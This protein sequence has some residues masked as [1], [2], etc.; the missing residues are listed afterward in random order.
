MRVILTICIIGSALFAGYWAISAQMIA[1]IGPDTLAQSR[2][3]D[4]QTSNVTGFPFA[5]RTDLENLRWRSADRTIVWD[6]PHVAFESASYQPNQISARFSPTHSLEYASLPIDLRQ[7]SMVANLSVDQNLSIV[8]ADLAI[9]AASAT[10]PLLLQ[11]MD[12]LRVDMNRIEPDR[13]DLSIAAQGLHLSPELRRALDPN[14]THPEQ[15]AY[16]ALNAE[17]RIDTPLAL[18]SPMPLPQHLDIRELQLDWGEVLVTG[19]GQLTLADTGG[20]DGTLSLT[21]E[22]WRVLHA[23]LVETGTIDSDAAMM[24]GLFLGSQAQAGG[25]RITL[26][27]NVSDSVVSLGPFALAQLPRF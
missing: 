8:T 27:L 9:D 24:A 25:T 20:L 4:A 13:Y 2:Q 16:L 3:F 5:F 7:T 21:L 22:D 17:T 19:D 11:N 6:M 23:L 26:S 18:N 1:R 15:I 14:G 12:S 10:P